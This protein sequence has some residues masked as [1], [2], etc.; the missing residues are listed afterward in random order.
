[1]G[2]FAVYE[3]TVD[4]NTAGNTVQPQLPGPFNN[5]TTAEGL[6]ITSNLPTDDLSNDIN[7]FPNGGTVPDPVASDPNSNAEANEPA[8]NIV[9]PA[10]LGSDL[11]IVKRITQV[12]RG[13]TVLFAN[14]TGQFNDQ[15]GD[16]NDNLLFNRSAGALPLGIVD[17]PT[18]LESGDVVEYT[19]YFFNAGVATAENIQLCD[20]IRIPSIL[21]AGTSELAGPNPLPNL[22]LFGPSALLSEEAPLAPLAPFCEDIAGTGNFPSGSI[23]ES[24]GGVVLD[25]SG[26]NLNLAPDEIAAFRFSI[27][28]P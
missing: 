19:A 5:Q 16:N 4:V 26:G 15:A 12:T 11:R 6:G 25:G 14:E 20:V 24:G 2:E 27:R 3:V 18:A 9:T 22:A 13:T 21:N 8:E 7:P 10:V 1:I 17:T 28:V 23:P